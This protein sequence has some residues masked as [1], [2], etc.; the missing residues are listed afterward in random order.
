M[1]ARLCI[2]PV[3][4]VL[5]ASAC[6]ARYSMTR[7]GPPGSWLESLADLRAAR[8]AAFRTDP[9]SPLPPGARAGFRGLD[10]FPPDPSWRYAGF[11]E[12]YPAAEK[13]TLVTTAGKARPCERIGRVTFERDGR[14]LTLQVYRLL[15]LPDR[16]GGEGMFLP[17]KDRTTGKETYPAGRYVDLE[18]PEG[19]PFVLDFNRAYDPSCAY[20][21]AAR[22][23]CPVTPQ[24]NTMPVPVA[25]GERGPGAHAP[26]TGPPR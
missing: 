15:D 11:V 10:Y 1:R 23:E 22:F 3:A 16:P 5:L 4:L 2:V 17:F 14:P 8:D 21:D 6:G 13:L 18:G 12:M 24:E 7:V 9:D 25:A 26:A 20:G 19:G